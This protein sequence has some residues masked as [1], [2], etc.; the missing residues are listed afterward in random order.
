[1]APSLV[2]DKDVLRIWERIRKRACEDQE[3]QG[4]THL[5]CMAD[6]EDQ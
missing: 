4:F 1:M 5:L 6:G 3:G 2:N